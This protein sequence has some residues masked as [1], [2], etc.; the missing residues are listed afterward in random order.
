MIW[1]KMLQEST[2]KDEFL[3]IVE[4]EQPYIWATQ[5]RNLEYATESKW[6]SPISHFTP[7]WTQFLRVPEELHQW[8]MENVLIVRKQFI[9][10]YD[11]TTRLEFQLE[12]NNLFELM[13]DLYYEHLLH[14]SITETIY[15]I[16]Y[17]SSIRILKLRKPQE[18]L[19]R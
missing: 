13:H 9:A 16:Y 6:P 8:A 15:T 1:A 5:L 7:K 14:E 4:N 18:T 12:D 3:V 17:I 2:S 11:M 10:Q 19:L